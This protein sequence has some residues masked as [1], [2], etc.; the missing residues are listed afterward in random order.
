MLYYADTRLIGEEEF[1]VTEPTAE[2]SESARL[3]N[4]LAH[5]II[6]LATLQ[7]NGSMVIKLYETHDVLSVSILF[8]LYGL[9]QKVCVLKPYATSFFESRQYLV[10]RGL[11]QR[12]PE[13]VI[14]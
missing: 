4:L 14:T 7:H 6:G 10:C 8:M 12:R 3:Q 1:K 11:K 13:Q 2:A 5:C 9:F